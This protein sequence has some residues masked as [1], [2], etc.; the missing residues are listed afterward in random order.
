MN[1]IESVITEMMRAPGV[2]AA[3]GQAWLPQRKLVMQSLAPTQL[4]NY[5]PALAA[6]TLDAARAIYANDP[7]AL[8]GLWASTAVR[9]FNW[10]I[11]Q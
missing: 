2:F 7:Y 3:E 8:A 10:L 4:K 1:S 9:P 11:K 5:F 6:I